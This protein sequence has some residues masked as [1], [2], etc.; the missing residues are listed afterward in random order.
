MRVRT[1]AI[2]VA[3]AAAAA[4]CAESVAP[5]LAPGSPSRTITSYDSADDW[6]YPNDNYFAC[7]SLKNS[8]APMRHEDFSLVSSAGAYE[9]YDTLTYKQSYD[10]E[11][12]YCHAGEVRLD[13]KEL[14]QTDS[15]R[16]YLHK[17][18]GGYSHNTV[19]YGHLWIADLVSGTAPTPLVT[20]HTPAYGAPSA[21]PGT[22]SWDWTK[23]NG[24]GCE[25]TGEYDYYIHIVEQGS[26]DELPPDWQYKVNQTSSRYNKYA[27]AGPEQGNGS[28]HYAY[29]VWSWLTKGDGVTTSPGGGMVR[30][31]L[32]D[33]QPFYR[34]GV[35]SINS[36]A[37]ASGTS[38]EVGRV[39]A[40][41]G[42]TRASEHG[43]WVYG[44]IIHSHQPKL[45]D[46]SY[47]SR[48]FHVEA[49][50]ASGC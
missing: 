30:A 40:I 24:R 29:L 9:V 31:L 1:L 45:S 3:A 48:I 38:T 10:L 37:Y 8:S 4:A 16:I 19:P 21:I 20:G 49:C 26:S 46:G 25:P 2:L 7:V 15:G 14:L 44:W 35:A 13:A 18:G 43:P 12:G 28:A 50:P 41:Y 33:G 23:R 6:N 22:N 27:D 17:G 36:K 42:K 39:T 11:K 5:S 32:K 34:C 47:G